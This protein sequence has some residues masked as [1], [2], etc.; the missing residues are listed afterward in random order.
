MRYVIQ[1]SKPGS[2]IVRYVGRFSDEPVFDARGAAGLD[3]ETAC[4]ERDRL[5]ESDRRYRW[6]ILG[7]PDAGRLENAILRGVEIDPVSR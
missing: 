4:A 1:A 5:A 3:L 6:S 7:C 2:P